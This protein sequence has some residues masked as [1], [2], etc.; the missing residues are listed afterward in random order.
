MKGNNLLNSKL[1][2]QKWERIEGIIGKKML[3]VQS[4]F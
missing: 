3:N 2:E 4:N 1:I